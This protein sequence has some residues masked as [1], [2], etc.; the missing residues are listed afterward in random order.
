MKEFATASP[1]IT[2]QT[3]GKAKLEKRTKTVYSV[4]ASCACECVGCRTR[5]W[6]SVQ[7]DK[8]TVYR[9]ASRLKAKKTTLATQNPST[10]LIYAYLEG[11]GAQP[12]LGTIRGGRKLV[13]AQANAS[14]RNQL[15]DEEYD[16]T[17]SGR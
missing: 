8:L 6:G 13:E 7:A 1:N 2:S 4:H 9:L 3:R 5:A 12:S 10:L 11:R 16:R 14:T 15:Q 17:R